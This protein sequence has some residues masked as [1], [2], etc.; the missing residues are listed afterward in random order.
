[1][2]HALSFPE[3]RSRK[4]PRAPRAALRLLGA[5]LLLAL[6]CVG[7]VTTSL[8][9][10]QTGEE[11]GRL[12]EL[13]IPYDEFRKI[14]GNSPDGI[15][16]DLEEYRALVRAAFLVPLKEEPVLP[17]IAAS[18]LGGSYVGTPVG[19]RV[20]IEGTLT[21][22]V[23]GEG[24]VRCPLGTLVPHLGSIT[25]DDAPGWVVRDG[26]RA[27]LLLRGRGRHVVRVTSTAAIGEGDDGSTL[28]AR[29]IPAASGSFSMT[30]PG[31]SQGTAAG[32]VLAIET[33]DD[34]I[35]TTTFTVSLGS[36]DHFRLGWQRERTLEENPL[37]LAATHRMSVLARREDPRFVCLSQ[38][39]V[40]RR[41]TSTLRF[42]FPPELTVDGV[43]G[44][45]LHAWTPFEGGIEVTLRE[46]TRGFVTLVFDGAVA[47]TDGTIAWAPPRLEN[48][49]GN[50]GVI[51]IFASAAERVEITES[52]GFK[53]IDPSL[54]EQIR[55]FPRRAGPTETA[56][57][58]PIAQSTFTREPARAVAV[59]TED[60]TVLTVRQ[61]YLAHEDLER[62][63]LHGVLEWRVMSGRVSEL[64]LDV[65][66]DWRLLDLRTLDGA[67][68]FRLE[69]V[70]RDGVRQVRIIPGRTLDRTRPFT[71]HVVLDPIERPGVITTE[72]RA[73][74]F[75]LPVPRGAILERSDLGLILSD[76]LVLSE[77]A[78]DGWRTIPPEELSTLLQSPAGVGLPTLAARLVVAVSSVSA[79]PSVAYTARRLPPQ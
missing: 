13:Y 45:L 22:L 27:D 66:L 73:V 34:G 79:T 29:V 19:E 24:W 26:D 56:S 11:R 14:A 52:T 9:A 44:A 21:I 72:A 78:F 63:R 59:I 32:G 23:T 61:T 49:T 16:I 31:L 58:P 35:P 75:P 1:M 53:A 15:V 74:A 77:S 2:K 39:E 37:L 50:R 40:S 3:F 41:R 46:P 69:E 68:P 6:V 76:V 48:A 4:R 25:V 30:V 51:S 62:R 60:P 54:G 7:P 42:T 55:D 33:A 70:V 12:R 20:Q 8:V 28:E 10:E 43:K 47:A 71:A 36:S 5:A 67:I 65:P 18:V 64:A 17:P 38:V 57:E